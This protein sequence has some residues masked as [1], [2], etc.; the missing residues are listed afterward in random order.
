MYTN[1]ITR[2]KSPAP[3]RPSRIYPVIRDYETK[4]ITRATASAP[5][6][7]SSRL[8]DTMRSADVLCRCSKCCV[9]K[10]A[11]SALM[12][13]QG[14]LG[15]QLCRMVTPYFQRHTPTSQIENSK[16][17]CPR[18]HRI[19][20]PNTTD[21]RAKKYF[22]FERVVFGQI[23][24]HKIGLSDLRSPNSQIQFRYTTNTM[25]VKDGLSALSDSSRSGF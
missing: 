9:R 18:L 12:G 19:W 13:T 8:S 23:Q 25:P 22:G 15:L 21:S 24:P 16:Y 7:R 1:H 20:V 5:Q 10:T 6:R 14:V 2:D 3:S 11:L 17:D 4:N